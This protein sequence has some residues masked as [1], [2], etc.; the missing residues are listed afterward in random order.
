MRCPGCGYTGNNVRAASCKLCGADMA[1]GEHAAGGRGSSPAKAATAAETVGPG[2]R[3]QV[4]KRGDWTRHMLVRPGGAPLD[5]PVDKTFTFGRA[6]EC[7]LSIP[8]QRVSRKHAEVVWKQGK[9]WLKDLGSQNGTQVNGRPVTGEVQLKDNDEV[10]VGPFT[11]TYRAVDGAGSVGLGQ[12]VDMNAPTI[13]SVGATLSGT[14]ATVGLSELLD[15]LEWSKKT[16][17][18]EVFHPDGP[19][20]TLVLEEGVPIHASLG[21]AIGKTAALTMMGW[22]DGLFRFG[23]EVDAAKTPNLEGETLQGLLAAAKKR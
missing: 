8:S 9:P 14:L 17:T 10:T 7:E 3:G 21:T 1:G 4:P 18:L 23:A 15:A 6:T 5:L 19:T 12:K 16:G 13:A 22:T 11:C 20:A 2:S